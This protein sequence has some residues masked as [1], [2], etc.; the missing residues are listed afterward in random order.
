VAAAAHFGRQLS[1]A[2]RDWAEQAVV[3]TQPRQT[4][5]LDSLELQTLEA[6]VALDQQLE[7]LEPVVLV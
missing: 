6:A 3:V 4:P 1:A 7:A 5:V 2:L